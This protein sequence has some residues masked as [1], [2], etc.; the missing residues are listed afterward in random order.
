MFVKNFFINVC[1]KVYTIYYTLVYL[2]TLIRGKMY[3]V[4]YSPKPRALRVLQR[5]STLSTLSTLL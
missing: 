4:V 5:L 2:S 3:S 1:K